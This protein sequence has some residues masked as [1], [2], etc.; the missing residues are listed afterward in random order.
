[1]SLR[2]RNALLAAVAVAFSIAFLAICIPP[3]FGRY[4][5]DV[6]SAAGDGFVNPMSSGY[7]LDTISCWAV[8]A[9]WA[10]YERSARGV[11]RG[12]IALLLG[13][14][15]GV[16]VGLASYLILRERQLRPAGAA[17]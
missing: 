2:T 8:L 17:S 13:I 4:S 14:V 6:I 1:M 5:G 12:W 15:P 7:S 3:L 11:R 9:I 10:A 16:A